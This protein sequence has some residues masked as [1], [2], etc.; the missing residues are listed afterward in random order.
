MITAYA[1]IVAALSDRCNVAANNPVSFILSACNRFGGNTNCILPRHSTS[2][3]TQLINY[4]TAIRGGSEE[5][6]SESL[7]E[8][9]EEEPETLYLPALL[10]AIVTRKSVSI[11]TC[12]KPDKDI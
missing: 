9:L 2:A 5:K 1:L 4:L 8:S 7:P 3:K 11:I 10:D 12:R 6:E